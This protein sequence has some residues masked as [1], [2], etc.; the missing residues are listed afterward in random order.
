[1]PVPCDCCQTGAPRCAL[2]GVQFTSAAQTVAAAGWAPVAIAA[3]ADGI[4]ATVALSGYNSPGGIAPSPAPEV[5]YT[6]TTPQNRV[7]G[8]RLWNQGGGNLNDFDG[9]GAFVA[10]FYAGATLLTTF[11]TA[12]TN[13]G[14]AQTLLLA[15]GAELNGVDRVV[16]RNLAKQGAGTIAPLWRELQLVEIQPVFP[17]RRRSGVLEWYDQAGNLVAAADIIPCPGS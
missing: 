5:T 3:T 14:A 1:M 11:N 16:I 17:C 12:G 8:L 13:G 7:R 9:L 6:H 4:T 10:D 2:V 15:A